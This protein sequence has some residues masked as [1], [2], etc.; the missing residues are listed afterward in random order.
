MED[1]HRNMNSDTYISEQSS[2]NLKAVQS[3][4]WLVWHTGAPLK[5]SMFKQKQQQHQLNNNSSTNAN[6]C[7]SLGDGLGHFISYVH[8]RL[9]CRWTGIKHALDGVRNDAVPDF[10]I[11]AVER[12]DVFHRTRHFQKICAGIMQRS[13]HLTMDG[14]NAGVMRDFLSKKIFKG[15]PLPFSTSSIQGLLQQQRPLSAV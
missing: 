12:K 4:K 14:E 9:R 5:C 11:V 13:Q 3:V 1:L 6:L 7:I 2:F 10:L 15:L 8:L